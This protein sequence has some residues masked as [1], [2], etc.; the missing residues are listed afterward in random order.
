MTLTVP[1]LNRRRLLT[2]LAAL[3]GGGMAMNRSYAAPVLPGIE[4]AR[5]RGSLGATDA[6]LSAGTLDD[7]SRVFARLIE[8]AAAS[9][10]PIFLPPG[11]Y[12]VSNIPLPAAPRAHRRAGRDAA[13]LWRRRPSACWPKTPTTSNSPA[14][15]STAP[16]AG[17]PTMRRRCCDVPP[18]AP[19]RRR[20]LPHHRQRRQRPRAGSA[21]G[22]RIERSTISGASEAGIYAVESRG[23]SIT[24]NTVTDC[25]NGGILVHRWQAGRGRHHGYRQPRRA[26]RRAARRHRPVRQRHQRVPRRRC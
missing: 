6:G 11:T 1:K 5:M 18:R 9:G 20:Q 26:H 17:S 21:V 13:A 8:A 23:L 7:Q 15:S 4:T 3:T 24:G 25:G 22:G 19:S 10:Q 2:G 14:S 12:A 16:T